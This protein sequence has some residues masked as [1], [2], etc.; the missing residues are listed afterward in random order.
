MTHYCLTHC[1]IVTYLNTSKNVN[2]SIQQVADFGIMNMINSKD[3]KEATTVKYP[4]AKI[5]PY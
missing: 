5:L 3:F 4:D 2:A 1:P